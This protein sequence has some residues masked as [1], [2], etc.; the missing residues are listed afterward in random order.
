[1]QCGV[2]HLLEGVHVDFEF[3]EPLSYLAGC[4]VGM[5]GIG[6]AQADCFGEY[7][8]EA[9]RDILQLRFG[10][11]AVGLEIGGVLKALAHCI[12]CFFELV[13]GV[14]IVGGVVALL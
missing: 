10:A 12:H 14:G 4:G 3:A 13:A 8:F 5:G 9:G 2:E 7:V 11:V 6:G 1:M